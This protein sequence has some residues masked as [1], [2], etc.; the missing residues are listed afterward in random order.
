LVQTKSI[1]ITC[2]T[3]GGLGETWFWHRE[4]MGQ[5]YKKAVS[6]ENSLFGGIMD[7]LIFYKIL[8]IVLFFD[9]LQYRLLMVNI[10]FYEVHS[11]RKLLCFNRQVICTDQFTVCF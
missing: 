5:E 8:F 1:F 10:H 4:L 11:L 3:K 6:Q 2:K 7:K 9:Q